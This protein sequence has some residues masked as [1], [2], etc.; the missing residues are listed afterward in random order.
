MPASVRPRPGISLVEV[1]VA[2]SL[3]GVLIAL[4]LP[5]VQ[6]ARRAA[7]RIDCVNRMRQLGL[8]LHTCHDT[9]GLM[10]G[11]VLI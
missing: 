6:D 2:V 4:L 5:A 8:A 7:T 10:P 11:E 3:I 1:L 9:T